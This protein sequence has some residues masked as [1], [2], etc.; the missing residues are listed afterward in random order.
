MSVYAF[1]TEGMPYLL[2]VWTSAH[3]SRQSSRSLVFLSDALLILRALNSVRCYEL[4]SVQGPMCARPCLHMPVHTHAMCGGEVADGQERQ[5]VRCFPVL[6]AAGADMAALCVP[7]LCCK[8]CMV[9]PFCRYFGPLNSNT[10][11]CM[12]TSQWFPGS[13]Q[14]S[15]GP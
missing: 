7:C 11:G 1:G 8:D 3:R 6:F 13:S 4:G 10:Q 9:M 5:V 14:T 12:C 15:Q 2:M